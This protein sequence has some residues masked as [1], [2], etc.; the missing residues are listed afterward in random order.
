MQIVC[1]QKAV[2]N[3][4]VKWPLKGPPDMIRKENLKRNFISLM[5][6]KSNHNKEVKL[7]Y[8]KPAPD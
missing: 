8:W 6:L 4:L 5:L 2:H 3:M 7:E 1:L